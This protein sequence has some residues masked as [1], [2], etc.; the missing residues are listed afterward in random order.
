M[1]MG[2]APPLLGRHSDEIL[3]EL[4]CAAADISALR[5]DGVL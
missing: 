5:S 2:K 4:G 3:R 1:T